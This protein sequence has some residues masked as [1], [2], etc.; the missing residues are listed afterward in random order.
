MSEQTSLRAAIRE[1][2]CECS[3]WM[4]GA[5]IQWLGQECGYRAVPGALLNDVSYSDRFAPV[6]LRADDVSDL[7]GDY[8]QQFTNNPAD[9]DFVASVMESDWFRDMLIEFRTKREQYDAE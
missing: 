2:L 3:H 9:D 1:V 4:G 7:L 8:W 6:L 5:V